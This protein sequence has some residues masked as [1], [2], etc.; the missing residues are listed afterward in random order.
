MTVGRLVDELTLEEFRGWQQF[1]AAK[2]AQEG[3]PEPDLTTPEGVAEAFK[4]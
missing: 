2:R 1:Y 3:G 4:I